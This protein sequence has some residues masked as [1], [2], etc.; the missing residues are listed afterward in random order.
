MKS[1]EAS[2]LKKLQGF[3]AGGRVSTT[4]WRDVEALIRVNGARL[5]DTYLDGWA[6]V[7]GVDSDL[8]LARAEAT[9]PRR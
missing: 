4:R 2:V 7:L 8:A 5:D 1:V 3:S 9:T 6:R